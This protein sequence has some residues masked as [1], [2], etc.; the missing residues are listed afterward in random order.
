MAEASKRD[1]PTSVSR[2]RD[3][4]FAAAEALA[5]LCRPFVPEFV[6]RAAGFGRPE[7]GAGAGADAAR[8]SPEDPEG[9]G[10]PIPSP[11]RRW[12]PREIRALLD[13]YV[14]G[15]ERAKSELALLL[16]MHTTWDGSDTLHKAPNAIL[17]GPTGVGK[18][19]SLRVLARELGLPIVTVDATSLVPAGIVGLQLE[20][21]VADLVKSAQALLPPRPDRKPDDDLRLA[22]RGIVFLDEFDK[23]RRFADVHETF[24]KEHVQRRLLRFVEGTKVPVGV[25]RGGPQMR[26][27]QEAGERFLDT[28][29]VLF[30]ASGAFDGITSSK[31]RSAR[32][33][34]LQ[35]TLR[36]VDTVIHADLVEYGFLPEL[37]ARMQT[38]IH[39]QP[40][41]REDLERI[42]QS[43]RVSPASFWRHYFRSFGTT[44]AVERAAV[45]AIAAQA[46]MFEM[47][48]RGLDQILFSLLSQRAFEL[49]SSN[50]KRY[51]L[52]ERDVMKGWRRL[53]G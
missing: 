13:G 26:S 27:R 24:G 33:T 37:V 21:V 42:L 18:T 48:A 1:T 47:G 3:P 19:H 7:D 12:T 9:A 52:K 5:K 23:V 14:V 32:P 4:L 20:D 25:Y 46:E 10:K 49:E 40:L 6:A 43:P 39:F 35:R 51:L 38:L 44:L 31:I 22:E 16:S 30:V 2:N 17:I 28:S 50:H 15:Q 34:S 41:E 53:D 36:T 8:P 45:R 29:G 11:P